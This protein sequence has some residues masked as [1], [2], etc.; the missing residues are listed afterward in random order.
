MSNRRRGQGFQSVAALRSR[1]LS[2]NPSTQNLQDQNPSAE[3]AQT[4][5]VHLVTFAQ[6]L[7]ALA[8]FLVCQIFPRVTATSKPYNPC[9]S[10]TTCLLFNGSLFNSPREVSTCRAVVSD[11]ERSNAHLSSK[12]G[13]GKGQRASEARCKKWALEVSMVVS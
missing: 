11:S 7:A 3:V 12:P 13:P 8:F 1:L 5:I 6:R 4:N 2:T 10:A 9:P